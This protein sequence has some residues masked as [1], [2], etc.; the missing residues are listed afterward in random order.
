[1]FLCIFVAVWPGYLVQKLLEQF[2]PNFHKTC[3]LN[4]SKFK[5]IYLEISEINP[6]L[7]KNLNFFQKFHRVYF[8]FGCGLHLGAYPQ[9]LCSS[10]HTAMRIMIG[11]GVEA[12]QRSIGRQCF[13]QI[14]MFWKLIYF[15]T[16]KSLVISLIFMWL[17]LFSPDT[18][19]YS[20]S[21]TSRSLFQKT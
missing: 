15:R 13:C 1:M 18:K 3:V 10:Y 5:K 7:A 8:L 12:G 17:S 6:V 19:L 2:Y 11:L 9:N 16:Q 14:L 4:H 21:L 20:I